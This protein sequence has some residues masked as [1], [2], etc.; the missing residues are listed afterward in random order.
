MNASQKTM[1]PLHNN[2]RNVGVILGKRTYYSSL[3]IIILQGV[4]LNLQWKSAS[5]FGPSINYNR[6]YN[7]NHKIISPLSFQRMLRPAVRYQRK[8]SEYSSSLWF[9]LNDDDS[10]KDDDVDKEQDENKWEIRVDDDLLLIGD[11]LSITVSA[12]LLG[13]VNAVNSPDF[14]VNGGWLAPIPAVPSTVGD[15]IVR[16]SHMGLSWMIAGVYE[17]SFTLSAVTDRD[18]VLKSVISTWVS[19]CSMEIILSILI[20]IFSS[21]E[22]TGFIPVDGVDLLKELFIAF[23]VMLSWRLYYSSRLNGFL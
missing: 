7:H 10:D 5:A 1:S 9:S 2:R 13:M 16:A 15:T 21:S 22:Y 12:L 17:V 19:F 6:I 11:V 23:P 20:A 14:V 8:C 3:I 4:I 18:S